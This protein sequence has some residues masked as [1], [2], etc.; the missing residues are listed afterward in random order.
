[1]VAKIEVEG[2]LVLPRGWMTKPMEV[3]TANTTR[4]QESVTCALR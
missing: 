3:S 2:V 4:K 1:M